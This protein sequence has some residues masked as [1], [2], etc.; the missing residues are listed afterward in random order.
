MLAEQLR[1][2]LVETSHDGAVAVVAADGA[3]IASAGDIDRPFFIRSSAKPFQAMV[4][5]G[6]GASLDSTELAMACASHRGFPVHIA[7]VRSMLE[8][9][10]LDESALQCPHDWPLSPMAARAVMASGAEQMRRIWHNCSGKHAGFLRACVARGWPLESYLTLDHPLQRRVIDLAGELGEFS[11]EPVGV[12][13]CGA[14]VLRTTAR[15]MGLMFARLGSWDDFSE[16]FAAMHRYPSLVGVNGAGDTEI[17]IATNC[18]AK[19]GA[20]GC[21]GVA[22]AGRFGLAVRSWDGLGSIASLAAVSALDQLGALTPTALAVLD[23]VLHPVVMGGAGVVG[24]YEPRLV[25]ET[26]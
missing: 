4:S 13:G 11:V 23:Q 10:G 15:A 8:R 21:I 9:A 16:V 3:L 24:R 2:G 17:A 14:P 5:Q 18:V 6:A 26:A 12:D 22:V 1:S 20:A 19:G 25:L 7:L